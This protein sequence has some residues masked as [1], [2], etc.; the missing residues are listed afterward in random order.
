[1]FEDEQN[2]TFFQPITE[3]ELFEVM[4][5]FKKDTNLGPHGWT[6]E[7][8]IHFFELFKKDILAM[9]EESWM[10]GSFHPRIT[11]TYISLIPK[12]KKAIA[13]SNFRPISLCNEIYKISSKI[14]ASR[15]R[16]TLSN[17]V[18]LEHH[19]F[20]KN[21]NIIEAVANTQECLHSL[22]SKKLGATIL[23]LD[24][25][26]AYDSLDWGFLRCILCK[27]GLKKESIGWIMA[28]VENVNFVVL[29]NGHP[30]NFFAAARGLRQGCSL[31]PLL[32]ILAMDSLSL[33]INCAVKED[34]HRPIRICRGSFISHSL[35]VDDIMIFDMLCRLTWECIHGILRNFQKA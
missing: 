9:V 26:K 21:R 33:H 29:I 25:K 30:T 5:S 32:F 10:R 22:H 31:S 2:N 35:F 18:S 15:I 7:F 16:G 6:I 14:I 19:G 3:N 17:Y 24:L 27:I 8:Y 4:K 13:F 12:K 20:L 1:M 23:Q 11:S 28:R 34:H